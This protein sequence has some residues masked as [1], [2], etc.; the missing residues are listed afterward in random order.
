MQADL[1]QVRQEGR[2][3]M[4]RVIRAL[5]RN[6][7]PDLVDHAHI[8]PI[9]THGQGEQILTALIQAKDEEQAPAA[10]GRLATLATAT[11]VRGPGGLNQPDNPTN[12]S[13]PP[14]IPPRT[15]PAI[16]A[17]GR[18]RTE[19]FTLRA[20]PAQQRVP[21]RVGLSSSVRR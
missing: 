12:C 1:E 9:Q 14:A 5:L 6:T 3:R 16:I 8:D 2:D 4:V 17:M 11:A 7:R 13:A 20:H 21:V 15:T 10:L 19:A 18:D